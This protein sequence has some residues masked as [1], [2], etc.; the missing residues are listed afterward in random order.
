MTGFPGWDNADYFDGWYEINT[1]GIAN[2][3]LTITD[4][5]I[6]TARTDT[7]ASQV[8]KARVV[9]AEQFS[10]KRRPSVWP[11]GDTSIQLA[12]FGQLQLDN[13][14][15][16][17]GFLV[18]ADLRDTLVTIK[19]PQAMA[20]G[21]A[22]LIE[23]APV[24]CTC[25]LDNVT[26]D[27]EDVIT[28][29]FKDMLSLL[30]KPLPVRINPPFVDSGAANRMVP[31]S[32]GACRNVA[33]LL[34]D[35]A[36]R[37]YQLHDSQITNVGAVRDMAAILDPNATPPQYTPALSASGIQLQVLPEGKLTVDCSSVGAQVTIPGDVDVLDGI[38]AFPTWS[39]SPTVPDDWDWTDEPASLLQH[40]G[41]AQGYPVDNIA[42]M[43]SHIS[44]Y[45]PLF[46]FGDWLS[47]EDDVL[48]AGKAYRITFKIYQT[49]SPPP[50]YTTDRKSVV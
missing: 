34:I 48:E 10:I 42:G 5:A 29:T 8:Y 15:G 6:V 7:P 49:S 37:L 1:E 30:D 13:Y 50:Y 25:I 16:F 32:F 35:E 4:E 27:N 9:N 41:T 3:Y 33:P 14:D 39:G 31:L 2:L 38:G 18:G 36:N 40:L 43:Y 21:T 22:T 11:W 19:L 26:C 47:T 12:A 45:P 17:Y 28:L 23:D 44:W 24:I 46:K 20:F